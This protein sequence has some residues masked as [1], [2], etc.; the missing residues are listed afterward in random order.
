MQSNCMKSGLFLETTCKKKST[1]KTN[2]WKVSSV[3]SRVRSRRNSAWTAALTVLRS[4]RYFRCLLHNRSRY[5]S[6]NCCKLFHRPTQREVAFPLTFK[7]ARVWDG[8]PQH[9]KDTVNF[10][11]HIT[12]SMLKIKKLKKY[13]WREKWQL[14]HSSSEPTVAVLSVPGC[15]SA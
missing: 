7:S 13:L 2:H 4:Q 6:Q 1:Y 12:G 5:F 10:S 14:S 9:P 3:F 11:T 15:S 8:A